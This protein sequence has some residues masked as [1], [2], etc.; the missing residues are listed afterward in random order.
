MASAVQAL[1]AAVEDK[2]LMHGVHPCDISM[3]EGRQ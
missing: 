2:K 3:S 1:E